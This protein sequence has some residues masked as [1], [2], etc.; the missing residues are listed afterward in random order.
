[1]INAGTVEGVMMDNKLVLLRTK[2]GR[3]VIVGISWAHVPIDL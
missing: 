2:G 3:L 1:M